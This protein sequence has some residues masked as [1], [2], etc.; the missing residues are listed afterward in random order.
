MESVREES[1]GGG[2]K[3]DRVRW[4]ASGEQNSGKCRECE[5]E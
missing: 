1:E 4:N 3:G 2:E 5:V